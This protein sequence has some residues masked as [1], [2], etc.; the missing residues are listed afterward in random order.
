M[1]FAWIWLLGNLYLNYHANNTLKRTNVTMLHILWTVREYVNL[2]LNGIAFLPID[3]IYLL[4]NLL[5]TFRA[6]ET[7]KIHVAITKIKL[8]G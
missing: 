2:S 1:E 3:R 7:L 6:N 5:W 8:R 4:G